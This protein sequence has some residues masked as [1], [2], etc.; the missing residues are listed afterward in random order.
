MEKVSKSLP[1]YEKPPVIEVVCGI[2]FKSIDSLLAPHLGLLW[3]EYKAEYPIC[4]EVAPLAPAIERFEEPT[5]VDIQLAD[6]PPLPRIWFV[7]QKENGIIQVQRDRFLHNWKK[8]RPEDEY[9]RYPEVINFFKDRLAQFTSF[10]TKNQLGVIE[11]LQYEMTYINHIPQGDGWANLMDI[12]D[13]FPDFAFRA[14]ENRFLPEPESFNWRTSFVLPAEAG[15]LH[16]KIR[17]GKLLDSGKPVLLLDLTVRGIGEDT[18]ESEMY[19]WFDTAREWIVHG[20]AELT[21]EE[22]QKNIWK[23]VD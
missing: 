21:G 8:I 5:P 22:V 19:K 10:L 11:P 18:S 13:V 17:N 2:L 14:N 4:R 12:G 1:N 3:E 9:P 7:H 20:F 15:R 23:T 6:V 16:V